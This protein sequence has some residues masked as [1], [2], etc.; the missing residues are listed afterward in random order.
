MAPLIA[1]TISRVLRTAGLREGIEVSHILGCVRVTAQ[2]DGDATQAAEILREA[3]YKVTQNGDY[4]TVAS[5]PTDVT[6]WHS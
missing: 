2:C 3:G 1:P 4:L 5:W 6:S